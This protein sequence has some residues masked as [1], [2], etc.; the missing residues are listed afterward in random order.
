MTGAHAVKETWESGINVCF[1]QNSINDPWYP[2]GKGNMMN[3]LNS[4]RPA[5][6]RR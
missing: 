5:R 1:G 2:V 6:R 3:I 4:A